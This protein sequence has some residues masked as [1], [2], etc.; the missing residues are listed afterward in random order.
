MLPVC[1]HEWSGAWPLGALGPIRPSRGLASGPRA[2]SRS[3]RLLH[4]ARGCLERGHLRPGPQ[5]WPLLSGTLRRP[6]FEVANLKQTFG[7]RL[8]YPKR[9][10]ASSRVSRPSRCYGEP[11][12]SVTGLCHPQPAASLVMN[13]FG[14]TLVGP[15]EDPD[16][17]LEKR[18]HRSFDTDGDI[19]ACSLCVSPASRRARARASS[20][21][22]PAARG[23]APLLSEHEAWRDGPAA[24]GHPRALSC[25][26][27]GLWG[28]DRCQ[29]SHRG[30]WARTWRACAS[31]SQHQGQERV[32][33]PRKRR[34]SCVRVSTCVH[35][36]YTCVRVRVC[37]CARCM[38]TH[39]CAHVLR[40]R[41]PLSTSTDTC[42]PCPALQRA[43]YKVETPPRS[44][45]SGAHG[46]L[47][48][49]AFRSLCP[50]ESMR[51]GPSCHR[52]NSAMVWQRG[53]Q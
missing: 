43:A 33:R 3:Q 30:V 16:P 46:A 14:A 6:S 50:A 19:S 44:R 20:P 42:S 1:P 2:L 45:V 51:E 27:R 29:R 18:P 38:S 34:G 36:M 23:G 4:V 39:V 10:V 11:V 49:S 22:S 24:S 8:A 21:A 35:L 17:F 5:G 26:S 47:T 12:P 53:S 37:L 9:L 32:R 28:G 7:A 48:F 31:G 13:I 25:V 41:V 52:L 15:F 40:A